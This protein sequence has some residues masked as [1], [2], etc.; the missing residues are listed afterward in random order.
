LREMKS[1]GEERVRGETISLRLSAA[2][3]CEDS[4]RFE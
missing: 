2:V 3:E 1:H 4:Y